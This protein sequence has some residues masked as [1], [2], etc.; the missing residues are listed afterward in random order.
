MRHCDGGFKPRS[1]LLDRIGSSC[2]MI[3]MADSEYWGSWEAGSS[4]TSPRTR[5]HIHFHLREEPRIELDAPRE[6]RD[7]WTGVS[8]GSG[9][10]IFHR[11]VNFSGGFQR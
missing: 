10:S 6:W 9:W 11:M 4:H 5:D 2:C 3:Q 8:D 1:L 7:G